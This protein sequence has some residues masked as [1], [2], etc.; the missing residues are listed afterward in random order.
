[1][2]KILTNHEM[3]TEAILNSLS[4]YG[5]EFL[6]QCASDI[7]GECGEC[8]YED[9]CGFAKALKIKDDDDCDDAVNEFYKK[10]PHFSCSGYFLSKLEE[11]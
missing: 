11:D 1:M 2:P 9:D 6:A 4:I 7:I 8:P 3:I 10:H 5:D